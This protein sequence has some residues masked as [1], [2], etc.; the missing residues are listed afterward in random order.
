[1]SDDLRFAELNRKLDTILAQNHH[2]QHLL[3]RLS[4]PV[5]LV[6]KD[7][8]AKA[9]GVSVR[10]LRLMTAMG[11]FT[12]GRTPAKRRT[13]ARRRW[14]MDEC[15]IYRTQGE[16]GVRRLREEKGRN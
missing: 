4:M 16:A 15:V 12:D 13:R 3:Q 10:E 2:I 7:D 6:Q 1:M 14:Y 11:V 5:E 9:A 8:A